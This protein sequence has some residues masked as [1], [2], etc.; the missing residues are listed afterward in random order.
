MSREINP[1]VSSLYKG[2]DYSGP[3][4]GDFGGDKDPHMHRDMNKDPQKAGAA[5]AGLF[6][7]KE[8]GCPGVREVAHLPKASIF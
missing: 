8:Q 3:C 1:S 5:R 4:G 2:N 7:E 6:Q